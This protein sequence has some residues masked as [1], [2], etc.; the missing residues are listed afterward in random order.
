ML[1]GPVIPLWSLEFSFHWCSSHIKHL[2]V[3]IPKEPSNIYKLNVT[4]YTTALSQTLQSL[5]NFSLSFVGRANILKMFECLRL[6]YLFQM[7]PIHLCP[8]DEKLINSLYRSF[9]WNGKQA[10][11]PYHI[12]RQPK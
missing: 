12:L 8:K 5:K 4:G 10:R 6:M 2:G 11:I 9:I 1:K 7:L 3:L